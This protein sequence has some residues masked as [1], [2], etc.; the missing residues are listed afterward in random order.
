MCY[1]DNVW[2]FMSVL[3]SIEAKQSK[4]NLGA[5]SKI[6]I[7]LWVALLHIYIFFVEVSQAPIFKCELSWGC[8]FQDGLSFF[9]FSLC[10]LSLF[11]N[12]V[13]TSL[14]N[15]SW[16]LREGVLRWQAP[17]NKQVSNLCFHC[18]ANFS[19]IKANYVAKPRVN[20]GEDCIST[21]ILEGMLYR[22]LPLNSLS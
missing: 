5:L 14:Q 18:L 20:V 8:N 22:A 11:R 6:I 2:A 15:G 19:L 10:H 12:V 16:F 13:W 21:W 9:K 17:V 7:I 1:I 4:Q 3:L